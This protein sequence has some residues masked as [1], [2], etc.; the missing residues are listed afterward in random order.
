MRAVEFRPGGR[1]EV[2]ECPVPEIG[3]GEAL[4]KTRASGICGSDLLDWYVEKKAGSVAGHEVC[5][6]IVALGPGVTG[7]AV[8]DRIVPHHH[9]PCLECPACRRGRFV[10]CPEWRSSRL[11]PGGMAERVRIPAGN[12][13]R[14]TQKVPEGLSDEDAAF[15][16]PLA[17]VV[18]AFRQ[19]RFHHDDRLLVIGLG[20]AGQLAIRY[21][22]R[23]GAAG[24]AGADAVASRRQIAVASGMEEAIDVSRE[25]LAEGARRITGGTGFD[26]VLV[27]PGRS[28]VIA[29]ALATVSRGGTLLLFTMPAPADRLDLD[30]HDV[31]FREVQIVPSYSCGPVEM[32][33]AL[34]MLS[35]RRLPVGDLVTH[36]F[37]VDRASEAFERAR[38]PEGS[39]KVM[40]TFA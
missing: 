13:S 2:V 29:E 1:V 31:Y 39:L 28:A 4:M 19:G 30:G 25:T 5:G 11:D 32:R 38:Q 23:L 8:G 33:L 24:I 10:Q 26:F 15:T 16:E 17:T 34:T 9:A 3:P 12:L 35:E 27:C 36:R 37:P 40:L 14:D 21:A 18:K 6:E 22:K 7:F 20:T